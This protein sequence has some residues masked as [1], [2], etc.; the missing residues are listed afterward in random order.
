MFPAVCR[1]WIIVGLIG[2]LACGL[3]C[4][5][6]RFGSTPKMNLAW[7]KKDSE[8]PALRHDQ[9][10]PPST[11]ISPATSLAAT[12]PA[13]TKPIR[14]P[15]Q[16]SKDATGTAPGTGTADA[17]AAGPP[18]PR[19]FELGQPRTA[20]NDQQRVPLPSLSGAPTNSVGAAPTQR[21]GAM[22]QGANL[23]KG[24]STNSDSTTIPDSFHSKYAD[25][26]S[27]T[28]DDPK[29]AANN[30][31]TKPLRYSNPYVSQENLSN[32]TPL[33]SSA[34][35]PTGDLE[36]E[37]KNTAVSRTPYSAFTP[38][39]SSPSAPIAKR[40]QP[41][42]GSTGNSDSATSKPETKTAQAPAG[43]PGGLPDILLQSQGSYAPGSIR[44]VQP[45]APPSPNGVPAIPASTPIPALHPTTAPQNT[46][47]PTTTKSLGGGGSFNLGQ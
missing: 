42:P 43:T 25:Q 46:A 26:S 12:K 7:W 24:N 14:E 16:L 6:T 17:A 39:N 9:L 23:V 15:Y 20:A 19:S 27:A 37:K 4:T 29:S 36:P 31:A 30:P 1:R 10:A 47:S 33:R 2:S 41:M 13:E 38:K 8:D 44:S 34:S 3:G 21:I 18:T 5:A 40:L 32:P 28:S 22:D 11:K 35:A 45:I